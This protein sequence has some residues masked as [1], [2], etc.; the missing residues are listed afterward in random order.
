MIHYAM[1]LY[2]PEIY[3]TSNLLSQMNNKS[4]LKVPETSTGLVIVDLE[5]KIYNFKTLQKI[6]KPAYDKD[7]QVRLIFEEQSI[8]NKQITSNVN[9]IID[10]IARFA[11]DNKIQ[12]M[13]L[14]DLAS[15]IN[16]QSFDE[17]KTLENINVIIT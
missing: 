10:N 11:Y 17:Q 14:I 5:K 8:E 16:N 12:T 6:K 7:F 3:I 1:K 2:I 9:D 4:F 15:L 13:Q